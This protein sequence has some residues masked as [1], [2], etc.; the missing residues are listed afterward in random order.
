MQDYL[1]EFDDIYSDYMKVFMK[2]IGVDDSLIQ[3]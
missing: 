3:E 1:V 2:E